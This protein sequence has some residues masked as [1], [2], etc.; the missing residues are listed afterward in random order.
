MR[1][2]RCWMLKLDAA[3]KTAKLWSLFHSRFELIWQSL[4]ELCWEV[5]THKAHTPYIETRLVYTSMVR[6]VHVA[7]IS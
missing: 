2:Q 5:P 7:T 6:I 1:F 3:D 4:L